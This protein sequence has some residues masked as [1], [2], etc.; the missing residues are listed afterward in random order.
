LLDLLRA[1]SYADNSSGR[2]GDVA[3]NVE[4]GAFSI[5]FYN[6]LRNDRDVVVSHMSCHLFALENLSGVF[7]HTNGT[8]SSMSL[9]HT[10]RSVLHSKVPSLDNTL[11][12]FTL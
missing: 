2:A 1:V 7:A 3:L 4:Q 6:L 12:T 10:V 5:N 9:T 11:V 8:S